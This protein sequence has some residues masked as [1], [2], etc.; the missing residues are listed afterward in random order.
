M[1]RIFKYHIRRNI[2]V[3]GDDTLVKSTQKED[4]IN[5]LDETFGTLRRYGLK[6]N[7]NKC[8]FGIKSGHFLSYM[9]TKR[10]IEVNPEKVQAYKICRLLKVHGKFKG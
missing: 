1:D 6:L 3:Y 8:I 7:P 2:E 10:G 5:N 4:L 9:V